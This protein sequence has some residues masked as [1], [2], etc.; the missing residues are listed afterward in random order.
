MADSQSPDLTVPKQDAG[1]AFRLE[2]WASNVLLGYWW[3]LALVIAIILAVVAVYGLWNNLHVN[4]QQE[5]SGRAAVVLAELEKTLI[6]D[7]RIE[8]AVGQRTRLRITPSY[9]GVDRSIFPPAIEIPLAAA[10]EEFAR[11]DADAPGV[12]TR[13]ADEL[14]AIHGEGSG[15]AADH[16]A[17]TAA[18]LYRLAGSADGEEKALAAAESSG[19]SPVRYGVAARRAELAVEAGQ[20]DQAAA[21]L[22]PWITADEGFW[23]QRAALDLGMHYL[24][25]DRQGDARAAFDELRATWPASPLLDQVDA[26]LEELDAAGGDAPAPGDEAPS[27]AAPAEEPAADT[28]EEGTGAPADG[29]AG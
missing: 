25:V 7:G 10:L 11:E 18:E 1:A 26:I 8:E 15:L 12:L 24:A 3:V 5:T 27:D 9:E 29:E 14:L 28:I 22:R 19:A 21:I 2:M 17:L 4:A 23:G 20:I 16:A 13:A 6:D